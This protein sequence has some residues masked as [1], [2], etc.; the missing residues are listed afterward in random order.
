MS[1]TEE[2]RLARIGSMREALVAISSRA[3]VAIDFSDALTD[4]PKIKE[5]RELL[6]KARV[7]VH[8]ASDIMEKFR[9]EARI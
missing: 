9:S 6:V 3:A 1:L 7:L 2:R 8:Q 5:A 4:D